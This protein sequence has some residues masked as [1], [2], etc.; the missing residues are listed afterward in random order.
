MSKGGRSAK[1]ANDLST[2]IVPSDSTLPV[3]EP[4]RHGVGKGLMT[5]QGPSLIHPPIPLLVKNKEFTVDT[6][7]SLVHDLDLDE[8]LKH[9]TKALGDSGLFD[10]KR[11]SSYSLWFSHF[12]C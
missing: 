2:P 4:R 6:A 11:V 12:S 8:C 1:S 10:M 7:R 5:S 9:D 3:L